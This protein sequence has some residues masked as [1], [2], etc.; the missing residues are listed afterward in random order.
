MNNI[1]NTNLLP[2][3]PVNHEI[4][5]FNSGSGRSCFT[6][7][8]TSSSK[9]ICEVVIDSPWLLIVTHICWTTSTYWLNVS[10]NH[11]NAIFRTWFDWSC[12]RRF[13][14]PSTTGLA[15]IPVA[16]RSTRLRYYSNNRRSNMDDGNDDLSLSPIFGMWINATNSTKT[17]LNI[18]DRAEE[19]YIP[20]NSSLT[21]FK[22]SPYLHVSISQTRWYFPCVYCR[23]YTQL[24]HLPVSVEYAINK[25]ILLHH[26]LS[27]ASASDAPIPTSAEKRNSM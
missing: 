1:D 17:N 21:A 13:A 27:I 6:Y 16:S 11:C 5:S 20:Q 10:T 19:N 8:D 26:L 18:I 15:A 12:H 25:N 7:F 4:Y 9:T 3:D 22:T 24:H 2:F 14:W 23:I